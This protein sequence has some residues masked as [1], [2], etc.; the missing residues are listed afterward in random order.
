MSYITF[1]EDFSEYDKRPQCGSGVGREV[2]H[3]CEWCGK[4]V[5][6]KNEKC[7]ECQE[8]LDKLE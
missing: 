5:A 2:N 1:E 6:N 3:Y 4:K 7:D 8:L